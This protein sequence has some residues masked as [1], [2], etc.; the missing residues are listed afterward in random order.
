[1]SWR[2][3]DVVRT[4]FWRRFFSSIYHI[5]YLTLHF[6]IHYSFHNKPLSKTIHERLALP[7]M[8]LKNPTL[9]TGYYFWNFRHRLVR[10]YWYQLIKMKQR[11]LLHLDGDLGCVHDI[12]MTSWKLHLDGGKQIFSTQAWLRHEFRAFLY[13]SFDCQMCFFVCW[14]A[15]CFSIRYIY[16]ILLYI[17]YIYYIDHVSLISLSENAL[18]SP[19]ITSRECPVA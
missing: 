11:F 17:I 18:Q 7:P 3:L 5:P 12:G 4:S 2:R 13:F 16:N 10:Y 9:P 19:I 15:C 1:M 6:Q 14:Q 8:Q